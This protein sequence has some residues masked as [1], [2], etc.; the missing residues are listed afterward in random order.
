MFPRTVVITKQSSQ[1]DQK[2]IKNFIILKI[3]PKLLALNFV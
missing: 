2:R 1:S 3:L